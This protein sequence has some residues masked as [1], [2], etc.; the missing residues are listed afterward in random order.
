MPDSYVSRI[1]RSIG[2]DLLQLIAVAGVLLR[3]DGALLLQR[4]SDDGEWGLPGG[5]VELGESP[6]EALVREMAEETGLAV[7]PTE[8]LGVVGPARLIYPN[9][10]LVEYFSLVFRCDLL[11]G[12]L[13][14]ADEQTLELRYWDLGRLPPS[15]DPFDGCS[16]SELLRPRRGGW[17]AA[18]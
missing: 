6:A 16:V 18:P 9:D 7:R 8:L 10:D 2:H 13:S 17:F 15:A 14:T 12:A 5:A 4:R 3:D 1:R 11:G